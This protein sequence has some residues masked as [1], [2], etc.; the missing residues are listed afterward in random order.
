MKKT[1]NRSRSLK[2]D[3]IETALNSLSAE[4]LRSVALSL[5]IPLE[6]K[7]KEDMQNT[8]LESG[9][10]LTGILNACYKAELHHPRKH[11]FIAKFSGVLPTPSPRSFAPQFNKNIGNLRLAY[12]SLDDTDCYMLFEHVV[13]SYEMRQLEGE[14][15][16]YQKVHLSLRHP[17]TV[18]IDGARKVI[19]ISYPGFTQGRVDANKRIHYVDVVR[20]L[21]NILDEHFGL[22]TSV[23]KLRDSLSKLAGS[24]EKRVI[25]SRTSPKTARGE[26][27][28]R[29]YLSSNSSA[30]DVLTNL[31]AP[32]LS[33]EPENLASGIAEALR[34]AFS[35]TEIATWKKEGITTR[36]TYWELGPEMLF[37][38]SGVQ[39][40][41]SLINSLVDLVTSVETVTSSVE[42]SAAWDLL[43]QM[44]LDRIFTVT[45]VVNQ[46]HLS[47][48]HARNIIKTGIKAAIIAPVFRIKTSELIPN[49]INEWI[50]DLS[51]LN[52]KFQ[53][54]HGHEIDGGDP[55]NVEIAFKKIAIA[56]EMVS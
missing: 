55:A 37:I 32:Y 21:L 13:Q 30:A 47:A 5:R 44:E 22:S 8:I 56:K 12:S 39:A 46:W 35:E 33:I 9:N 15:D 7:S 1:K 38:W 25:V 26:L 23:L 36:I 19:L 29:G 16:L 18:K 34:N 31:L 10:N 20:E 17:V 43:V 14:T 52:S 28:L 53:D 42:E 45:E 41:I 51:T 50:S 49:Y 27:D 24:S 11:L 54:Q 40:S 6:G 4:Q 48:E 2:A 3:R